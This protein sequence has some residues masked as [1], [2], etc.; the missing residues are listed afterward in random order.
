MDKLNKMMIVALLALANGIFG[1]FIAFNAVASGVSGTGLL[2]GELQVLWFLV[3]L[4]V[5]TLSLLFAFGAWF[6]Y[7][8]AWLFGLIIEVLLLAGVLVGLSGG[9]ADLLLLIP[10][11]ISIAILI[12][13]FNPAVRSEF[14]RRP[15]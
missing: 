13:L 9:I 5:S 11:V 4:L 15:R 2:A 12:L 6:H 7:H 1:A 14:N 10:A 3:F 8:W